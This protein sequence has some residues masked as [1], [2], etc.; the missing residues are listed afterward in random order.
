ME[1][2]VA[3][4]RDCEDFLEDYERMKSL[5][6]DDFTKI[7]QSKKFTYVFAD[8]KYALLLKD[9]TEQYFYNVKKY[10]M[11]PKNLYTQI[12]AFYLLYGL[13]YKQPLRGFVKIRLTLDEYKKI[14]ELIQTLKDIGQYQA[15]FIFAKMKAEEVF[16]YTAQPET[17]RA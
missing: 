6:Y 16:V 4:K 15:V 9:L 2:A 8:Q 14:L 7:W 3:F 13:Y 5:N 12:G 11:F 1:L 10:I 17:V